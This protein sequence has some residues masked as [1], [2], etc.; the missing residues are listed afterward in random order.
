M[1]C[2]S[3]QECNDKGTGI[4]ECRCLDRIQC[5]SG[6]SRVCGTDGVTYNNKC[7]MKVVTCTRNEHE[8]TVAAKGQCTYGMSSLLQ[9]L[10]LLLAFLYLGGICSQS[11]PV[12][13][14]GVTCRAS[15]YRYWFN[16]E[17]GKC[18]Q[19]VYGGCFEGKNSFYSLEDCQ[20]TCIE[21][22]LASCACTSHIIVCYAM[23]ARNMVIG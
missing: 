2:N 22:E 16:T 1:K 11:R 3:S 20:Q 8:V 15:F 4:Y 6:F 19:Y 18:E 17:S 5:P 7:L 14:S 9:Y 12:A 13:P 21:S 23:L 10:E